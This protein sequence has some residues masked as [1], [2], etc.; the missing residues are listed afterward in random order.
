MC[1]ADESNRICEVATH[2]ESGQQRITLT[3]P[4][5]NAAKRVAFLITGE[6]KADVLSLVLSQTGDYAKFP[7]S[8]IHPVELRFYLDAAAAY[9]LT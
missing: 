5:I 4:V 7:T 8:H 2:P 6:S 9:K 1:S 3:G